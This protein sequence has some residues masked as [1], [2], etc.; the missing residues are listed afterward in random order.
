MPPIIALMLCM[1]FVIYLL[2]LDY[3]QSRDVSHFTWIP[4]IWALVAFSRPIDLWFG[5]LEQRTMESGSLYDRTF[6]VIMLCIAVII[7]LRRKFN[8]SKA[9]KDNRWLIVLVGFMLISISWSSISFISFRRWTRE[10][11]A[12]IMAFALLSERNPQRALLSV[13]RRIGYILIPFSALLVK[14]YPSYGV[15]FGRWDGAR[16]WIGV[17]TQKNGLARLCIIVAVFLVWT[18]IRRW[19]HHDLPVVRSQTYAELLLLLLSFLLL[20]GPNRT[21]AYSATS[22]VTFVAA[23]VTLCALYWRKKRGLANRGFGLSIIVITIVAYGTMTPF[24]G[25]LSFINISSILNRDETLTGRAD[26]IWK[27]LIPFAM[28]KPILG[29]GYGGFWTTQ[30]RDLTSSH[31]HNGYLDVILNIGFLGLILVSILLLS[32]CQRAQCVIAYDFEWGVLFV[33]YLIML[34]IF[35][36]PESAINSLTAALSAVVMFFSVCSVGDSK[37]GLH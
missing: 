1:G 13:L 10:L 34:A 28:D 3:K 4:S 9:V 25:K 16:S 18:L 19:Q 5:D 15:A 6:L 21:L 2:W 33:C 22:T 36:I 30:M 23:I 32:W 11:I 29:H 37:E 24:M 35:N 17:A 14:F 12:V 7:L 31:A 20:M 26:L 8:W 27:K